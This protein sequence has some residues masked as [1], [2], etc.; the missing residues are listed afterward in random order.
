MVVDNVTIEV[1]QVSQ[2]GDSE[3]IPDSAIQDPYYPD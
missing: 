2:V 1:I 3:W